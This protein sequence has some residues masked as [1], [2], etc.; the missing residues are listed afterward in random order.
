MLSSV[1]VKASSLRCGEELLTASDSMDTRNSVS[2]ADRMQRPPQI[3][4]RGVGYTLGNGWLFERVQA[5]F[6]SGSITAFWG[7]SGTGKSTMMDILAGL[8]EPVEGEVLVDGVNQE[9]MGPSSYLEQRAPVI[10]GS[11]RDNL[12]LTAPNASDDEMLNVMGRLGLMH[13]VDRG[14]SGIDT[15]VG[16]DGLELSGGE[17]QRLAVARILLKPEPLILLDEPT[18][19]VDVTTEQLIHQAIASLRGRHTI[20]IATHRE[21]TRDL[22]DYVVE[23][24]RRDTV[25]SS[26]VSPVHE[27]MNIRS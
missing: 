27:Q 12:R 3:A 25:G 22:C 13:L 8:V 24:R 10:K 19:R 17:G 1:T 14:G 20:V 6:P 9:L 4:L 5:I 26:S 21:S 7:P 2:Q 15:H 16:E 23:F 18:S 11:I